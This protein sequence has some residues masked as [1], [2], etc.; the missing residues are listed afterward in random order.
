MSLFTSMMMLGALAG[1]MT[2]P[3]ATGATV[4]MLVVIGVPLVTFLV[5]A[6]SRLGIGRELALLGRGMEA[7]LLSVLLGITGRLRD[8]QAVLLRQRTRVENAYASNERL[9]AVISDDANLLHHAR[10]LAGVSTLMIVMAGAGLPLI[11]PSTFTW[12]T[13]GISPFVIAFD[14]VTFGLAGRLISERVLVRLMETSHALSGG[15]KWGARARVVPITMMLGS[16]LGIVGAMVVLAAGGA[17][18][19]IETTWLAHIAVD[20]AL[21]SLAFINATVP[22]GLPLGIA[23]GAILGAGIGLAQRPRT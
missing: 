17:A 9:G 19:A 3:R 2:A 6:P 11:F 5:A 23:M 16:A 18:S 13:D 20:P 14:I 1:L 10:R 21:V 4:S 22:F 7:G 15:S 12:G 8:A